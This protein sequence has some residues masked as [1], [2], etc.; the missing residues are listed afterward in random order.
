MCLALRPA[1]CARSSGLAWLKGWPGGACGLRMAL[2]TG[3]AFLDFE[4]FRSDFFMGM[5][6]LSKMARIGMNAMPGR[7]V[8]STPDRDNGKATPD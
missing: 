5:Q 7:I 6:S 1:G 3:L 4:D 8:V 2:K